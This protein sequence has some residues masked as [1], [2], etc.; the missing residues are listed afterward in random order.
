MNEVA[1]AS[2]I[3]VEGARISG[4]RERRARNLTIIDFSER[5]NSESNSSDDDREFE[6]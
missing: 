5:E 3:S 2:A 1:A 6:P 4:A